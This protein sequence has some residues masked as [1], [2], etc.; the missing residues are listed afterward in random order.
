MTTWIRCASAWRSH[1]ENLDRAEQ[2]N[3]MLKERPWIEVAS[4]ASYCVQGDVLRLKP[5]ESPPCCSSGD[6]AAQKLLQKML[7]AGVSEFGPNPLAA[8]AAVAKR[9]RT[10]PRKR[11]TR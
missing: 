10:K 7:K 5:W 3:S 2:L 4:F 1:R 8:L 6:E 9:R 11:P